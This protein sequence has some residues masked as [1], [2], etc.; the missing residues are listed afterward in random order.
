M[1]KALAEFQQIYGHEP[2]GVVLH[3]YEPGME[4]SIPIKRVA[5]DPGD[6]KHNPPIPPV[7]VPRGKVGLVFETLTDHTGTQRNSGIWWVDRQKWDE[8]I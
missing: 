4:T 5:D 3:A 7:G 8:A 1:N 2:L 6:E